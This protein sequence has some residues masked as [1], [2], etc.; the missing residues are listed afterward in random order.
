MEFT[1]K[2]FD[3]LKY[4][5]YPVHKSK[6]ILEYFPE[7]K[8]FPE[9]QKETHIDKNKILRY[10]FYAYDKKTPLLSEKNLVKRKMTACKLAG[11]ELEKD[12]KYAPEVE[13]MV[14]SKNTIVNRMVC[15][16]VRSQKDA[17]YALLIAGLEMFYDNLSQLS[18]PS[19]SEDRMKD[20]VDR[21]KLHEQ[22]VKMI[23]SLE[24]NAD[25]I[26]N[27]DIQ[28]MYEADEVEGEETK[29]I[30]SFPEYMAELRDEGELDEV[31]K[32]A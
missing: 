16:F 15:C 23:T 19:S 13:D 6:N 24:S 17:H 21:A 28:L 18:A 10:I 9:Y 8:R 25:E 3:S 7:L 11:F 4:N 29:R 5:P 26:F 14:K 22:T 1:S 30:I 2:D 32:N 31:F 12:G 20:M 27:G